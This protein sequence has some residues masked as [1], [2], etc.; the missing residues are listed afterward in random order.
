[1]RLLSII[2]MFTLCSAFPAA[3]VV[4]IKNIPH[5]AIPVNDFKSSKFFMINLKE[6]YVVNKYG[7]LEL[8]EEA[9][10]FFGFKK[11]AAGAINKALKDLTLS[12][13]AEAVKHMKLVEE[14]GARMLTCMNPNDLM[15]D[16]FDAYHEQL[17]TQMNESQ[18]KLSTHFDIIKPIKEM[19]Y[20]GVGKYTVV[21]A[22]KNKGDEEWHG[23]TFGFRTESR[24]SSSTSEK[25]KGPYILFEQVANSLKVE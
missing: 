18:S 9:I 24:R 2:I 12:F 21:I 3:E 1:M 15:K 25:K 5:I 22:E 17:Q 8:S 6:F 11:K 16:A 14:G 7:H 4:D 19:F 23:Y 13:Y 10:T 20:I